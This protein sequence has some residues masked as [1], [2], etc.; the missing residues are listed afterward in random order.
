M[1][2]NRHWHSAEQSQ[3]GKPKASPVGK[4]ELKGKVTA[5]GEFESKSINIWQKKSNQTHWHET[6]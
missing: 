6:H 5:G 4:G 1:L 2:C 3:K